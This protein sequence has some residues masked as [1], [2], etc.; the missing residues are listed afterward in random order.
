MEIDKERFCSDIF[1]G[2]YIDQILRIPV[3]GIM[4]DEPVTEYILWDIRTPIGENFRG[5][6]VEN[7][8]F[9]QVRGAAL[10]AVKNIYAYDYVKIKGKVIAQGIMGAEEK[11][12]SFFYRHWNGDRV[13][14]IVDKPEQILVHEVMKVGETNENH[15]TER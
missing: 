8:F 11:F 12:L 9:V 2:G 3:E 13:K 1:I 7:I 10:N 6:T 14:I 4:V 15:R 5:E